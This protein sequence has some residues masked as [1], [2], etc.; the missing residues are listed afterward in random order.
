MRF[1][2]GFGLIPAEV[3]HSL[4]KPACDG[5]GECGRGSVDLHCYKLNS[6]IFNIIKSLTESKRYRGIEEQEKTGYA[7]PW[8]V[9][10]GVGLWGW[11]WG[12]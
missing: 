10:R 12:R 8:L 6:I 2:Y 9:V 11:E 1:V 4:G 7:Y 3:S 5:P